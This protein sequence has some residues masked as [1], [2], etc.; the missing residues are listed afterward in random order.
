[1]RKIFNLYADYI[2]QISLLSSGQKACLLDLIFGYANDNGISLEG[3]DDVVK[4][5][6]LNIKPQLDASNKSFQQYISGK[7][8]S[9]W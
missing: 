4:V 5:I 1:M 9:V 2:E 7:E 8:N 6:F 3:V